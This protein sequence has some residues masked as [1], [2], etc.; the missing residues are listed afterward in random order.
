M[1]IGLAS[2]SSESDARAT[3]S[4]LQRQFP[5]KLGASSIHRIDRGR[6]GVL[7]RLRLGPLSL[8]AASKVCSAVRA[9]GKSCVL[10]SG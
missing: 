2:S 8:E 7:Y 10:T 5:G 4:Q 3:L 1:W 6:A 9:T